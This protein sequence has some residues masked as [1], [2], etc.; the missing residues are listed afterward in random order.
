MPGKVNPT[1]CE[2]LTMVCAQVI[3][4]H[5]AVTIGGMNGQFELNVFKPLLIRNLLHSLRILS[6]GMRSFE[7]HLVVGLEADEK[8]INLLLH[9][10]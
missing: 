10:R 7:K 6:D 2:A 5:T 4:N 1:Q 8:R 3:G 9:E